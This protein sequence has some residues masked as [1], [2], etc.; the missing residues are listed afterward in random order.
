ML[1]LIKRTLKQGNLPV[2]FLWKPF[3]FQRI[4]NKNNKYLI[5]IKSFSNTKIFSFY[6]KFKTVAAALS[7][8]TNIK[9]KNGTLKNG[10]SLAFFL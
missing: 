4:I 5:K 9:V 10:N 7:R 6:I 1:R 2:F 3:I 8:I